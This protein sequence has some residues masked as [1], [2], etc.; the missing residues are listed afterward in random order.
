M[1][2]SIHSP[3]AWERNDWVWAYSFKRVDKPEEVRGE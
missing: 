1:W 3:G 2:D